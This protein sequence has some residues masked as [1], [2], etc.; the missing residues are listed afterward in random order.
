M[1]GVVSFPDIERILEIVDRLGISREAVVIPLRPADP[2]RIGRVA[3]GK[4]EIVV[5]AREPFEKWLERVE[6]ELRALTAG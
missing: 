1:P 2:G 6:A 5:D 3:G 4:I